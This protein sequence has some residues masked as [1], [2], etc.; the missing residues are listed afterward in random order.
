MTMTMRYAQPLA[1]LA[2]L[3]CTSS[4]LASAGVRINEISDKGTTL[5]N[6]GSGSDATTNAC[7][8]SDWIELHNSGSE[9]V[10]LAGYTLHDDR[11][12]F[13][14]EV[15]IFPAGSASARGAAGGEGGS[16]V[17]QPGDF[18]V[19][20]A[21]I[22]P[23]NIGTNGQTVAG[24]TAQFGIGG[25]DTI[26]LLDSNGDLVS[27]TATALDGRG[28]V[29]VTLAWDDSAG[30]G[31]EG[32]GG[33]VYTTTPTPGAENVITSLGQGQQG[34]Q[35]QQEGQ[36]G[37]QQTQAESNEQLKTKLATQ[38]SLAT[39][40]FN[41][42]NVGKP[43]ED[44]LPPVLDLRFT[45]P[46]ASFTALTGSQRGFEIY[47]PFDSATL[48][49][50]NDPTTILW[51]GTNPG[52]IRPKGQST[53]YLGV[54]AN[55]TTPY[56]IDWD[57]NNKTANM[58]GMTKTY[59]RT[60]WGD[61]SFSREWAAHRM[62]ARFGLPHLRTRSVRL[63]INDVVM[64][65]YNLMEAPDQD[66]VFARSFPDFDPATYGL[67]KVKTQSIGCG[68]Y[69]EASLAR[70][71]D[72]INETSTPPYAFE[73]GTH[74]PEPPVMGSEA[75]C[76]GPFIQ[77]L[78]VDE[79]NDV[80]LA[81]VRHHVE[82]PN[83]EGKCGN[84]LVDQGLVDRDLGDKSRDALAAAFVDDHLADNACTD[85]MCSN[86]NLKNDVDTPQFLRNMAVMAVL[87]HQDSPLGNGNNW[88]MAYPGD[89]DG[90]WSMVQY[91]HNNML[92]ET[93]GLLCDG[94]QCLT[95]L[96][97]WSIIRPTCRSLESN[98]LV[99]PL[100]TD[101]ALRAEYIEYVREFV[102]EVITN[103][104]FLTE[105]EDHLA[106]IKD[107]VMVDPWNDM[108]SVFESY[109]MN[110]GDEW[111][112]FLDIG[113]LD[114]DGPPR[115]YVP[116]LPALRTRAAD[117]QMQLAALDGGTY[118]REDQDLYNPGEACA[119]WTSPT[120]PDF[121]CHNNCYYDGC[122]GGG[123]TTQAFCD[124]ES[125]SCFRGSLD[126][127]CIGVPNGDPA[128]GTTFEEGELPKFCLTIDLFSIVATPCPPYV[129][130]GMA[131]DGSSPDGSGGDGMEEEEDSDVTTNS[132][133]DAPSSDSS[134][135]SS[136]RFVVY[137]VVVAVASL[138]M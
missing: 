128:P 57:Y 109:E 53:M 18:M 91:D 19:I 102:D 51:A 103:E 27:T 30:A 75:A 32:E 2:M 5:T 9:V 60:A 90:K 82:N 117:V 115:P 86:S 20:C 99:G 23:M 46:P 130:D 119:N 136:S 28:D 124:P 100:L 59:L 134:R 108:A 22:D 55:R 54:C 64:G 131:D 98:Q 43:V 70:A 106:S 24:P 69:D 133:S 16:S 49:P 15:L 68:L 7:A 74:R 127:S 67:Y 37:Q 97:N 17:M 25:T 1:M 114:E 112:R 122:S 89:D 72:R 85:S 107:L 14:P 31:G 45:L 12:P 8:G 58:L 71:R 118:P 125:G 73:R 132:D 6:D 66:Y 39:Q 94:E 50:L 56:Q 47:S 113:F 33:Y 101:D 36:Q 126:F 84:F 3:L 123:L 78:A 137:I 105:V 92:S 42:N 29:D 121:A 76:L 63:V 35:G 88:Y 111:L 83:D 65:L 120:A 34:E 44:G 40:F 129:G 138:F 77:N 79:T 62:L 38:N 135:S 87:L 26:T 104:E 81:Y 4:V 48:T 110:G 21:G 80:Q 96:M 10:D 11:G 41:M 61:G 52:R 93:T 116:L 95:K 13:H